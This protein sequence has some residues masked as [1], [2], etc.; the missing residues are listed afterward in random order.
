MGKFTA[1]SRDEATILPTRTSSKASATKTIRV[2]A[3]IT[4]MSE[5]DATTVMKKIE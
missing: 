4:E 2:P 5:Q 3:R 1:I